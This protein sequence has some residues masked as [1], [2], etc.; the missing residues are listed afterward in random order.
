[1]TEILIHHCTLR[2]VRRGEWSWGADPK[3]LVD[4]VVATFPALLARKLAELWPDADEREFAMPVRLRI[5]VR[6]SELWSVIVGG[7]ANFRDEELRVHASLERQL[8]SSLRAAFGVE[9]APRPSEPQGF[10]GV[11]TEFAQTVALS[12]AE[13]I[14]AVQALLLR[15][16]EE[17][18]LDRRLAMLTEEQIAAWH[19]VIWRDPVTPVVGGE[20]ATLDLMARVDHFVQARVA[21]LPHIDPADRLRL[22]LLIASDAAARHGLPMS[23]ALLRRALA[24]FLPIEK[25][26]RGPGVAAK[27]GASLARDAAT[28]RAAPRGH[29]AAPALA[30]Q[31]TPR[32]AQAR[33]SSW[34]VQI[35]CALP[36]LL[37][38]PLARLGYFATLAAVLE[39]AN[40]TEAAPLFAASLANKVLETPKRGWQRSS[41]A[42]ATAAAFAGSLEPTNE[43]AL[44]DFSRQIAA[45]VGA[46]DLVI[47]DAVTAGHTAGE[48]LLLRR[49]GRGNGEGLLLVDVEGCF[50]IVCAEDLAGLL[51]TLNRLGMATLLVSHDTAA[52][53]LLGE[54]S[55]AGIVWIA[56]VPPSR[57][58]A[59]RRVQQGTL[60]LG[61]TNSS[62]PAFAPLVSGGRKL[63]SANSEAEQLWETLALAR[64]GVVGA[65]SPKLDRSLTMAAAVALGTVAW[66]LWRDRGATSPLLA[67]ERYA[68]LNARIHFDSTTLSVTLP[69]GRRHKE[70]RDGGLLAPVQNIPWLGGR[71]VEFGGG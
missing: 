66:K 45:H 33:Q 14:D 19:S 21:A 9:G 52:P 65:A 25:A 38:G 63:A 42:V 54:L 46:L 43:E 36:F 68:D 50:P 70:L 2:I 56:N 48:P 22:R 8:E 51:P 53:R 41:A 31:A 30:A 47:A 24:R 20:A 64:P 71:R 18:A 37:L 35:T 57:G 27:E 39:A 5:P 12:P 23:H 29:E 34:D 61:W 58:E 32:G 40:L 6:L 13:N 59:Y 7:S 55:A 28:S 60:A 1:M 49:V 16:S 3:R 26:D 4:N 69:L 62:T 17:G 11:E 10:S 44:V 67:L 15:W